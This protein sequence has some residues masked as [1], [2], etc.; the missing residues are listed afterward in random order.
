MLKRYHRMVGGL[1]R[2]VDALVISGVWLASYWL[3]FTFPL[4]EVTKGFPKFSTYAALTPLI[5]VLWWM[6]FSTLRIY[7]PRRILRR[8]DEA[9]LLL[10]GS[11]S[12]FLL[13]S[14][15]LFTFARH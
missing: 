6:V 13:A 11:A 3:R 15:L 14:F 10:R 8:T 1:F 7:R 2:V 4:V 9:L 5:M 12:F